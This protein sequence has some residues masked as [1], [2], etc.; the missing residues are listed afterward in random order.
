MRLTPMARGVLCVASILIALVVAAPSSA[1]DLVVARVESLNDLFDDFE[2]I[3]SAVGQPMN[4]EMVLG[5]GAQTFGSD[6]SA[7]LAMDRPVAAV[8]PVEG[9]MMMQK[10][11][12][13]AVPVTDAAAAIE[14]LASAYPNHQVEGD[15][16]TFTSDEGPPFYLTAA[17]GYVR[18]GG[19]A[20][21]VTT[22]DPLAGGPAGSTISIELFLEP[23][24]PMIEAN[25]GAAKTQMMSGL[26]SEA[27][28]AEAPFDPV[29]MEP[30]L[31]A[32]FDGFRWLLA[33][34]S[35]IRLRL[36]VENGYVRFAKDL[37]PKPGGE[38]AVFVEAQKG[39][40]PG[41]AKLVDQEA[42]WYM[43]GR[44]S[45]TDEHR[46]GLKNFIDGY[47]DVMSS[48]F[49]SQA[50]PG[51]A[52]EAGDD[53]DAAQAEAMAFWTEYM[54]ALSPW[55]GRWMECLRGDMAASFDV[56]GGQ[57]F[58][59]M[60]A[61]GLV[62]SDECRSLVSEMGDEL[63]ETV[64]ASEEMS[65][66]FSL[67]RGPKIAGAE[68]LVMTFD[69]VKMLDEMGEGSDEQA[70]AMITAMYG[71]KMSGAMVTAGDVVL[72][73]GGP[74]AVDELGELAAMLPKP[75]KVPSFS[76][77]EVRPGLMFGMNIG[78]TLT[79]MQQAIPEG[80]ADLEGVADRLSGEVGRVPMAMTF[81][82]KMATF[83]IA[84]S[85]KT[86]AAIAAIAQEQKTQA[87]GE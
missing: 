35:S 23:V 13:V 59:F 33:N 1:Q 20:N 57:P 3:A 42:A 5:M 73:A 30:L 80:E 81:G 78:A 75:G 31:D 79:W 37:K 67:A 77:L 69:M 12:V 74:Q 58:R 44:L 2:A 28:G 61:F 84:V 54:T 65:D 46:Q 8:M 71:E 27:T 86:I 15:L 34:T 76:P 21:L 9:M 66:T 32:Y 39:G 48:M 68:S 56:P 7:F 41:I 47:M 36:D 4:R 25:L 6:P 18:V 83:D 49:D 45:L 26:E 16:H 60:E 72:V 55:A 29:S 85:L 63:I 50:G 53:S 62:D 51:G 64:G 11:V 52:G 43:A 19:A 17:D 10:G 82:S 40:L 70:A 38:L 14:A 24:A 87:A 22:L